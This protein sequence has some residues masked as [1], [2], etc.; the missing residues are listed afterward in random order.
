MMPCD[1]T[2]ADGSIVA[3]DLDAVTD[4]VASYSGV[5]RSWTATI[6]YVPA[7]SAFV[8]LRSSPQDIRGNS[9]E[10]SVEV[11]AHYLQEFFGL[12][13]AQ[14][15]AIKAKPGAWRFVDRRSGA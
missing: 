11:S 12:T 3:F 15:N 1:Y 9:H 8:E 13:Q 10:E 14:Q 2:A 4:V 6:V 7:T 5:R